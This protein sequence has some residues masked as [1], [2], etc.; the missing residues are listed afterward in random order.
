[1]HAGMAGKTKLLVGY[2]NEQFVHVP[3]SL[4]AGRRK[5]I[6]PGGKLWQNVIQ[7]TGQAVMVND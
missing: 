3:L 7:A 4:P 6:D 1:M 5:Q 2:W